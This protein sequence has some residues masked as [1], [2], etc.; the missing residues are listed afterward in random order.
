M[1]EQRSHTRTSDQALFRAHKQIK[2]H[3]RVLIRARRVRRM[4]VSTIDG[5]IN[6]DVPIDAS[7]SISIRKHVGQDAV[8]SAISGIAAVVLP[9]CLPWSEMLTR[10]VAPSDTCPEVIDDP[11]DDPTTVLKRTGSSAY[12]R[13]QE[14]LDPRPL[15]INED[16]KTVLRTYP[17]GLS[18]PQFRVKETCPSGRALRRLVPGGR[19]HREIDTDAARASN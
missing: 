11:L 13:E 16:L 17:S 9:G 8:P 6:T 7:S 12:V 18:A 3:L 19:G 10:Q 14:R 5:G 1:T 4:L 15:V 2:G